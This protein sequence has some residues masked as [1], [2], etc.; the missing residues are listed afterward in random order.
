MCLA[1]IRE[2]SPIIV[3]INLDKIGKVLKDDTHYRNQHETNTS[4]GLLKPNVRTKWEKQLFGDAYE[5]ADAFARPKYGV[6][7]V[8]N[9]YRGVVGCKQYGDSYLVLKDVRLRCT[10]SPQDS[11]NLKA[12]RLAVLDFYA[13]VL[14]EYSDKELGEAL[15]VAQ[16]GAERL[17][18][19]QAVIDAW[20]KY[21]EAQ[22]HG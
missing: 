21:K 14:Q 4:S 17:G 13:H 22:I 19:S 20:G 15:R 8:W 16:G 3:H 2:L 1:W 11:G 7:N 5:G 9:D 6:Q 18:D 12:S 10:L